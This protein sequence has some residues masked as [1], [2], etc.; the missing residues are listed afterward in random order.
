MLFRA[1]L[2]YLRSD[3]KDKRSALI[4][5]MLAKIVVDFVQLL[6]LTWEFNFRWPQEVIKQAI[7]KV[8]NSSFRLEISWKQ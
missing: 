6:N 8:L 2:D 4:K 3:G 5:A 7:Y 1:Y